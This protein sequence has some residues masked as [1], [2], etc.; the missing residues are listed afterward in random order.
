MRQ[1]PTNIG[2]PSSGSLT[3]DQWLLLATIYGPVIIPQLWSTC[4]PMD[5][6][7]DILHHHVNAIKKAESE[8]QAQASFKA[9]QKKA[10]A[11][12]KIQGKD[13]YE[14]EKARIAQ[15]KLAI[16]EAKIQEKL[17]IAAA[18]QAGKVRL[19]AEKKA[20]AAA[21]RLCEFSSDA[22]SVMT[23]SVKLSCL[24]HNI[25]GNLYIFMDLVHSNQTTTMQLMLALSFK[26]NNHA[27]GELETTFFKEF[28]RTCQIGRLIYTLQN[29][30]NKTLPSEAAQT[31]L[32]ASNDERGTVAALAKLS[33]DLDDA[34][35]DVVPHSLPLNRD[36]IFFDYVIID[37]LL[38]QIGPLWFT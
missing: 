28:Q 3:A 18:R 5:A 2:M 30:P 22:S 6:D 35:M 12:A 14:A 25:V 11:A 32:K 33:Q 19:T 4:L 15:E 16:A 27:H 29:S 20:N 9:N 10:L 23:I 8:K 7:N 21:K 34:D 36:A 17:R 31:M 24:S 13:A 1:L 37:E 38:V 26:T